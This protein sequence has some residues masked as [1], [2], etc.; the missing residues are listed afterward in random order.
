MYAQLDDAVAE[1]RDRLG[2]LPTPEESRAVW[3]EIWVHEAHNST[4]LE[5]NTLVLREVVQL[6]RD[7]RA[8]G[9]KQLAEYLE[10]QGY[11]EAA[12]WVDGQAPRPDTEGP[13][14]L[15]T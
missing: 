11:A 15:L 3:D 13:G 14:E 5:G 10:V 8:V 1:L 6:L 9:S 2:G 4:A 7:G 12:R